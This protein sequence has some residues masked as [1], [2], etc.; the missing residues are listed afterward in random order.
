MSFD[1]LIDDDLPENAY[2]VEYDVN[3]YLASRAYSACV[4]EEIAKIKA[5][6]EKANNEL[7]KQHKK[8]NKAKQDYQ[9]TQQKNKKNKSGKKSRKRKKRRRRRKR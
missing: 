4:D 9:K 8:H 5:S 2:G 1:Q 6:I 7:K 3:F